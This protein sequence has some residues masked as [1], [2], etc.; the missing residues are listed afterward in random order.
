MIGSLLCRCVYLLKMNPNWP[1]DE[2]II[3]NN[4][5]SFNTYLVLCL[6]KI[7]PNFFHTYSV[8]KKPLK[9]NFTTGVSDGDMYCICKILIMLV[10]HNTEVLRKHNYIHWIVKHRIVYF[11][12]WS[13][14]RIK[15]FNKR[16]VYEFIYSIKAVTWWTIIKKHDYN[17]CLCKIW[18]F[19]LFL[20]MA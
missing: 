17:H 5:F 10:Y 15:V 18:Q 7:R 8:Q 12:F 9:I 13:N 19:S 6:K 4:L 2:E 11:L 1:N 16:H 14:I 3:L 20:K